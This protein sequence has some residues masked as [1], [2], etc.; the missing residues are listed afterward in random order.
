MKDEAKSGIHFFIKGKVQGVG[1]RYFTRQAASAMA[2]DGWVRNLPDGRVECLVCGNSQTLE[3]FENSLRQGP[4][5]SRVNQVV[6]KELAEDDFL[7]LLGK[8][9]QII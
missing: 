4:A 6:K 7:H 5:L 2:L 3:V 1:F 9:F 8:G